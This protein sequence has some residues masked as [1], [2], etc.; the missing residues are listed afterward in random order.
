M[1]ELKLTEK[2][3]A[4]LTEA[5]EL[6]P[7][8]EGETVVLEHYDDGTVAE[9]ITLKNDKRTKIVLALGAS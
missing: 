7:P 4:T 1:I 5:L 2:Q 8:I 6:A 9:W 3:T